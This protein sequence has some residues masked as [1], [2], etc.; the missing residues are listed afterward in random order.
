V[1]AHPIEGAMLCQRTTT[2]ASSKRQSC[3][4]VPKKQATGQQAE[5]VVDA[6]LKVFDQPLFDGERQRVVVDTWEHGRTVV[7]WEQGPHRWM[8]VFPRGGKLNGT[9]WEIPEAELPKGVWVEPYDGCAVS[10]YQEAWVPWFELRV[11]LS[12]RH[13]ATAGRASGR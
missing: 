1:T 9:P 10:V 7:V 13:L 11:K 4:R 5:A 2:K 3:A 12:G 6:L 8:W